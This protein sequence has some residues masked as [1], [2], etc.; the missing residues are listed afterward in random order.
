MMQTRK[1][2][3]TIHKD[4]RIDAVEYEEPSTNPAPNH[5]TWKKVISYAVDDATKILQTYPYCTFSDS[6]KACFCAGVRQ[7]AKILYKIF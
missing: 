7:L 6:N 2:I 4:G 5:A 1:Y 3:V